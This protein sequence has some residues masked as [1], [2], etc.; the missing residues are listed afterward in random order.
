MKPMSSTL[1]T[2]FTC[3]KGC[4]VCRQLLQH[5]VSQPRDHCLSGLTSSTGAVFGLNA[6]DGVQHIFCKFALESNVCIW[7]QPKYF[8]RII[9]RQALYV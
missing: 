8:W 5:V 6:E 1:E 3:L 7:M 9:S 2:A 4:I